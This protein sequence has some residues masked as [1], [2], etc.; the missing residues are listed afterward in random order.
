MFKKLLKIIFPVL[1]LF[2]LIQPILAD[3]ITNNDNIKLYFFYGDG[4]PHCAKEEKFL[5]NLKTQ[6]PQ[7][8]LHNFEIY[9]NQ[10]NADFLVMVGQELNLD[11]RGVPLLIVGD[12]TFIGFYNEKITGTQIRAEIE[13]Y[14]IHGCADV[15]AEIINNHQKKNGEAKKEICEQAEL[16]DKIA[17]PM[18]GEV[19]IKNLSL[20]A[21][22]ILIAA[23]DGFN[24]CAMWIL[25]FLI[26]LL[27]GMENKKRMWTLGLAFVMASGLVYFLFL[28]AWLNLFLFLGFVL[29]VRIAIGLVAL[30]SGGYHIRDYWLNR[31]GCKVTGSEKRKM[32]F[33]KLRQIAN[34]KKF[35]LALL[36]IILLAFAVNLVELICSAGLPAIYTQVLAL[37]D[38]AKWQYYGYLILYIFIFMLDD[39]LVFFIAMTTLQMK[40]IS[41]RYT[42]YSGLIGGIILLIIGILLIFKYEWLMLG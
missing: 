12:K 14:L 37:S 5:Q 15:V 30:A 10:D 11:V 31:N 35:W 23:I 9:H 26:S 36:G 8:E 1:I 18:F 42:R 28:S 39:L 27:L 2:I 20:P 22:T 32:I 38:L 7:I 4:C 17:I 33:E 25:L 6:I 21:L 19:D 13:N 29:W 34:A 16:P 3:N 41:S 40:A 24:P